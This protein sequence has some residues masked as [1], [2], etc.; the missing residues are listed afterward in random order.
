MNE[1]KEGLTVEAKQRIEKKMR[2]EVE[3][4]ESLAKDAMEHLKE[5]I[6]HGYP[7]YL[8]LV[9]TLSQDLKRAVRDMYLFK[10]KTMSLRHLK[11]IDPKLAKLFE[12]LYKLSKILDEMDKEE[13]KRDKKIQ[14]KAK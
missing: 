10:P 14:Q 13:Y 12:A 7:T 3:M 9:Q 5:M 11:Q 1:K 4:S 8:N 6:E 2:Q